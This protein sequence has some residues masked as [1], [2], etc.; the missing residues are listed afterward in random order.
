[1]TSRQTSDIAAA[2]LIGAVFGIGATLLM[3]AREEDEMDQ[4]MRK[5]RQVR[6]ISLRDKPP[7][8]VI[9]RA[10]SAIKERLR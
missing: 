3:R 8:R 4:L 9:G 2:F 5:L 6:K 1:M 10:A 7:G